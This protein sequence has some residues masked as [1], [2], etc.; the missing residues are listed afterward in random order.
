VILAD[1]VELLRHARELRD[2]ALEV[3]TAVSGPP[4]QARELA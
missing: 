1:P 3:L 2:L 4:A